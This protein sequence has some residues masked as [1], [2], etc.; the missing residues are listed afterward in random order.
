[1]K[2][3]KTLT[4][5]TI[6][7]L[8]ISNCGGTS[9]VLSTPIENIDTTPLKISELTE[10]EKQNWGHLDL[11]KDTI[12]G[13]SVDKAYS[14]IIKNKK[15]AS[16]IVAVIDSGL[17]VDHEDLNNVIWN[18]TDEIPNNGKD[19]DNNGYIDDIHGWN[20]LGDGYDEQLE[21]V[22]ILAAGDAS[23][24]DYERAQKEYDEEYSKYTEY[25]TRYEQ[26]LQQITSADD[27]VAK[28]LNKKDYTKEDV[29][30]IETEDEILQ[31][32]VGA[33]KYVYSEM[34]CLQ[35]IMVTEM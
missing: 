33:I 9:G 21:F 20:F 13:M 35:N 32:A 4:L 8:L 5:S 3:F 23:N 15:G 34:I 18:N 12:P 17:D 28:H 26:I 2:T 16:V 6:T 30:G 14:E 31:Q 19:D 11:V 27:I 24:P 1:M 29:N 7:A 22:R 10:A 25:K